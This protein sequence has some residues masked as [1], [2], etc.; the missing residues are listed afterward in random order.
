MSEE[1]Q[2]EQNGATEGTPYWDNIGENQLP[3]FNPAEEKKKE[4]LRVKFLDNKPRKQTTNRY[5]PNHPKPEL[6]FDVDV[7]G[8]QMTW[9]ISQ[10]S[11][12]MALKEQGQLKDRTF[13]IKLVKV[14]EEFK[15]KNPKYKGKERYIVTPVTLDT[16][17]ADDDKQQQPQPQPQQQSK[18]TT[19]TSEPKPETKPETKDTKESKDKKDEQEEELVV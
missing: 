11:L 2:T 17:V 14:D 9:T 3:F 13:D 5:D 16:P 19:T 12:L 18:E 1:N 10:V 8:N 7:K 4:G 15:K 6:W